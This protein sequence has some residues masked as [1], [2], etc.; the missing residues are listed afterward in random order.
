[1]GG[2]KITNFVNVFSLESFPLY[3]NTCRVFIPTEVQDS[4]IR[5][6]THAGCLFRQ[7]YKIYYTLQGLKV[8]DRQISD[9]PVFYI[10]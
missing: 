6:L 8:L 10:P 9:A 5:I 2:F 3:S 1:M 4:D 7:K